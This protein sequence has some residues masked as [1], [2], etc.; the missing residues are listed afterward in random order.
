MTT[1]KNMMLMKLETRPYPQSC[2][3]HES[4]TPVS[5]CLAVSSAVHCFVWYA[6]G[7]FFLTCLRH[8]IRWLLLLVQSHKT[9]GCCFV[10]TGG[11]D[12]ILPVMTLLMSNLC[13]TFLSVWLFV[14][15]IAFC[16]NVVSLCNLKDILVCS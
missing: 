9:L 11:I 12:V 7:Y 15:T 16:F 10:R 8:T 4:I 5:C 6:I 2:T 13:P 3:T 1:N 14:C